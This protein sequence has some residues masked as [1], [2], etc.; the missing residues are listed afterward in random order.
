MPGARL[1]FNVGARRIE[2]FMKTYYTDSQKGRFAMDER[3]GIFKILHISDL[4]L[5]K[6]LRSRDLAEDQAH[7]LSSIVRE[8]ARLAPDL[9]LIAGDIFDRS[10]PSESAQTMFGRFM[11]DLRRALP[12]DGRILVIPGNHD[13]AR[14]VAFAAELFEAVGIHLVSNVRPVPALVLEKGGKRAAVWALPFVTHGAFHEFRR[15]WLDAAD[16]F[17]ETGAGRMADHMASIIANLRPH[18]AEYDMNVLAAHCYVCGAEL[19]ES[20]SAFIGGTEAVPASLFEPFDYVALGHLHRMQALSPHMWYSG[21]PMAMSF[22]DGGSDKNSDKGFLCVEIDAANGHLTVSPIALEP[23]RKMKR[24]R[25]SFS[26]LTK[27]TPEPADQDYIEVVLTDTDPVYNAFSELAKRFPNLAGVQQE[28]FQKIALGAG[29]KLGASAQPWL[30]LSRER[31]VHAAVLED[32]RS[33]AKYIL[34]KEPAEELVA[35]FEAL[36]AEMAEERE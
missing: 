23:L 12:F 31:N 19:S 33:F 27:E 22:G 36:I 11:A 25:G 14:R 30:S 34:D 20:D 35:A 4:H 1:Y 32:F 29:D 21:A 13:S 3:A 5:G 7:I 9:V 28:A 10:I 24:V 17:P 18:F 2:P 15:T 8:T 16:E 6:S 26:E